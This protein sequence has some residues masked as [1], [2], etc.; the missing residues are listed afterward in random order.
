[1]NCPP[2]TKL[3]FVKCKLNN[4]SFRAMVDTGS[5]VSLIRSE[6]LKVCNLENELRPTCLV[7]VSGFGSTSVVGFLPSTIKLGRKNFSINFNVV[8]KSKF[9][10]IIGMDFIQNHKCAVDLNRNIMSVGAG[11]VTLELYFE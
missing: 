6:A 3:A 1:M 10:I 5:Q 9:D 7:K 8:E 4:Y 2:L 11:A